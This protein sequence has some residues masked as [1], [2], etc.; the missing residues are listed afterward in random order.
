VRDKI[1][2]R[3]II[4]VRDFFLC[5]GNF[6]WSVAS[7]R[8]FRSRPSEKLWVGRVPTSGSVA[9]QP[10]GSVASQPR[11]SVASQ[12]GGRSRPN[13]GGRSRPNL[14]TAKS[15][16]AGRVPNEV[17]IKVPE[18]GGRSRPNLGGRSRP[19]LGVGRVPT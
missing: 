17:F 1:F 4:F 15:G 16:V 3:E 13:L 9:S 8:E 14:P 7:H 19:N 12:P 10:R 6:W 11:G 5:E 2:V 18:T